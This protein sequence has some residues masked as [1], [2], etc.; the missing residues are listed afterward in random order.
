ML[1]KQH[2]YG[3]VVKTDDFSLWF[4]YSMEL[5]FS[6]LMDHVRLTGIKT[7]EIS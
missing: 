5:F 6:Q 1:R 7:V 4:I 3:S 2:I